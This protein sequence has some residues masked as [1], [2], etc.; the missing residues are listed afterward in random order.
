MPA[1]CSIWRRRRLP[2]AAERPPGERRGPS[3]CDAVDDVLIRPLRDDDASA[4]FAMMRDREAVRMAA[5]TGPDPDD[6]E[7]FDRHFARIRSTPGV[8]NFAVEVAGELVGT[9]A[10]FD[11]E[12]DREVTYWIDRR[13]WGRGIARRAL[14]LLLEA[15]DVRP[16]SARAAAH[17]GGSIRVLEAN[18]FVEVGREVSFADGVGADV[19]EVIFELR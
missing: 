19:E 11:Q 9:V 18:G 1:S 6:R 8:R 2:P 12:G 5:F 16:L 3:Y 13:W 15:E 14:A 17:N 7:A 10:A 4:V